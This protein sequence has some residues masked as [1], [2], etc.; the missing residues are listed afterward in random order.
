MNIVEAW[1][2][3]EDGQR[4]SLKVCTDYILKA[5]NYGLKWD[6]GGR[7]HTEDMFSDEWFVVSDDVEVFCEGKKTVMTRDRAKDLNLL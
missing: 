7:V 1:N 6:D 3:A 4:I 5:D 2:E